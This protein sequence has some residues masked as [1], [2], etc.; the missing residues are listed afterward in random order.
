MS[1][2]DVLLRLAI[3]LP[4][5][6]V[7]GSFLTVAIHRVPA[8]SPW[9]GRG[10]AARAAAR[11]SG[12][13]QRPPVLLARPPRPVPP[14]RGQ[15]SPRLPAHRARVRRLFVAVALVYEDPGRPSCSRRSWGSWSGSRSSTCATTRS[16][17]PGLP[18]GADLGRVRGGGGP[19]GAPRSRD[20][21]RD[22]DPRVR[23]GAPDHRP[24]R[25]EG[26]GDGRREARRADRA[27]PRRST[28]PGRR[29]GRGGDRARGSGGPSSPSSSGPGGRR[30]SPTDPSWPAGAAVAV[31]AGE[32][33][34]DAYLS[35][36][37]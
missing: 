11:R 30:G 21:G 4:L 20:R 10:R 16:Q 6:L 19:R 29:R 17:S 32:A 35:L 37:A 27:R 9:C 3:A 7:F 34:V 31:F 22:R 25:P 24:D 5:G 18:G 14:L 2:S 28:C 12:R 36:F 1:V 33:I 23:G 15:G 26:H 8:G 13:R